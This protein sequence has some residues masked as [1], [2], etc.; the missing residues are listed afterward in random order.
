MQV[1]F[2]VWTTISERY[3]FFVPGSMTLIPTVIDKTPQGERA[4]DIYSRLLEDRIIFVSEPISDPLS[5]TVIAQLLYLEKKDPGKD[6]TM[7]IN[8]PGGSITAG[9]AIYD[10]MQF[11]SCD[12]QTVCVGMAASMGSVLLMAGTKGK[13]FI[14]PNGEVLIHQPLIQGGIGGQATE[15]EIFAKQ[16]IKTKERLNQVIMKHTGQSIEKIVKDTDRDYRMV[17]EEALA[18]GIVDKIITERPASKKK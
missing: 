12:I 5:S 9:M 18:Y 17:A 4:Y 13:R 1:D 10:T 3:L 8:S 6:I 7:Y 11:V 2:C 14:L 15:I 16:M